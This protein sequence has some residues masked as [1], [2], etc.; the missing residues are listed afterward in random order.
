MWFTLISLSLKKGHK[1]RNLKIKIAFER[2]TDHTNKHM[3]GCVGG[4]LETESSKKWIYNRSDTLMKI[5]S[6]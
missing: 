4:R 2:V 5:R 3:A 1:I 6:W